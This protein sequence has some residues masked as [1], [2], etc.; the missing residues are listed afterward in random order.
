MPISELYTLCAV[1][2]GGTVVGQITE[3]SVSTDLAELMAADSGEIYSRLVAAGRITPKIR[4]TTEQVKRALAAIPLSGKAITAGAPLILYFQKYDSGGTRAAAGCVT[5]T[6]TSGLILW[7]SLS[8]NINSLANV[9]FEC[10]FESTDGTTKPLTK[11]TG[12]SLPTQPTAQAYIISGDEGVQSGS[13]TTGA[14][15]ETH[16]GDSDVYP[17]LVCVGAIRPTG[18][19]TQA[20]MGDSGL[21]SVHTITLLDVPAGGTRGSSPIV[22]TFNQYIASVRSIGGSPSMNE[23]SITASYDGTNAPISITGLT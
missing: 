15:A 8:A 6:A 19:V 12:V 22:F 7:Q 20:D 3:Q 21:S 10:T 9:S 11:A 2:V 18:T 14:T 13:I 16:F 17:T 1:S 23:H 5:F 4:F